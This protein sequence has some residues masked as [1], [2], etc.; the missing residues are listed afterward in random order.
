MSEVNSENK[1]EKVE[2]DLKEIIKE[3]LTELRDDFSD[4]IP[5]KIIHSDQTSDKKYKAVKYWW[6]ALNSYLQTG[7][8]FD[9]IQ[10]PELKKDVDAFIKKYS[11]KEFNNQPRTTTDNINEANKTISNVLSSKLKEHRIMLSSNSPLLK[12][13]KE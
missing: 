6:T 9:V 10:E 3:K 4:E 12:P 5:E 13:P 11:S 7:I 8:D 2:V 1:E